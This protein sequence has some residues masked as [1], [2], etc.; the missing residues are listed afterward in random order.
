M[1]NGRHG[2]AEKPLLWEVEPEAVVVSSD[3]IKLTKV[4]SGKVKVSWHDKQSIHGLWPTLLCRWGVW[5]VM[6]EDSLRHTKRGKE[7]CNVG[8]WHICHPLQWLSL[9][10]HWSTFG[11]VAFSLTRRWCRVLWGVLVLF[12]IGKVLSVFLGNFKICVCFKNCY[13]QFFEA[14]FL[15]KRAFNFLSKWM[16]PSKWK[17]V[18]WF[19]H[20]DAIIF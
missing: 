18:S 16:Q 10:W 12:L 5:S 13:Y 17:P 1:Y 15:S 11:P 19:H 7:C 4:A 2:T 20:T 3:F 8:V 14:Y 9:H 6:V